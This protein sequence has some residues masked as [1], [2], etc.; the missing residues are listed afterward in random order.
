[1]R[2]QL[3]AQEMEAHREM[4]VDIVTTLHISPQANTDFRENVNSPYL[5]EAYPKKGVLDIWTELVYD[6]KFKSISVEGLLKTINGVGR[7]DYP[8]WVDYLNKRYDWE[9]PP[10][11]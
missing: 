6:D 1:M 4:D 10:T 7:S 3:L 2:L 8:N 9:K 11:K 5:K